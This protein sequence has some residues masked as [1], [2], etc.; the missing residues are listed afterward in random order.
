MLAMFGPA[1]KDTSAQPDVSRLAFFPKYFYYC[2]MNSK[3][4]VD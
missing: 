3:G 2:F 1:L 4:E